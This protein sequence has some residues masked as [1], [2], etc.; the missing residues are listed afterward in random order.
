MPHHMYK[1][2]GECLFSTLISATSA[3]PPT[4]NLQNLQFGARAIEQPILVLP[5]A[6]GPERHMILPVV[7]DDEKI[8]C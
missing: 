3:R 1:I 4:E 2:C 6:G 7:H 5:T 8:M